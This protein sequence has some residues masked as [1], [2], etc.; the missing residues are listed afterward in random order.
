MNVFLVFAAVAALAYA[1]AVG[2][3]N[4]KIAEI[5]QKAKACVE[6]EGVTKEQAIALKAGN[7]TDID[8]KVKCFANCFLEK[9]GLVING[10]VQPAVVLAKLGL[11]AGKDLV[12]DV[13][14]KCDSVKG[15]DKCDTSF[16][17]YKCYKAKL[18]AKFEEQIKII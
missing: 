18:P 3:T 15:A 9:S 16:Q 4:E 8:P 14:A 12:K 13:Q 5:R 1:D 6:Q 11:L 7:F 10:Q 2:L 17:L